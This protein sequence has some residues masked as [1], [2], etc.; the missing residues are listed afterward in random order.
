M[1]TRRRR[2]GVYMR[3]V[4]L[5]MRHPGHDAGARRAPCWSAC[6]SPMASSATASSSSPMSSRTTASCIVHARGNLSLAEKDRLVRQVEERILAMKELATVYASAGE[7]QGGSSEITEDMIGKIQ[8]EFVDWQ[9]RR[10]AHDIMDEIRTRRPTFPAS[11]VE[12]TAPQGRSADR[13]ADPDAAHR[14]NPDALPAAA[15]KV[16]A[17]LAARPEVRDLDNGLPMP[18]IDW[19]ARH[20]QGR[21]GQVRHQR[22]DGWHGGPARDQWPEDHRLPAER[23]RQVGRH[24]RA[25]PGKPAHAR[26]ARRTAHEHAGRLGADRQFHQAHRRRRASARSTASTA[27]AS[28]R[29]PPTSRRAC[30]APPCSRR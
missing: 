2:D 14:L 26:R 30:R 10:P 13:Q 15:K 12:V 28:S 11:S 7:G 18:G 25:L 21:G 20:Q 8:F 5:A 23:H 17:I 3:I 4:R 16:A 6:R 24:H 27:S 1:T 22:R 19:T 29:S 9:Q